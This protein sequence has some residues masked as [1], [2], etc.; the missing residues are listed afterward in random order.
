MRKE[1]TELA[2]ARSQPPSLV[3]DRRSE[4]GEALQAYLGIFC[5]L[6]P[7][8]HNKTSMTIKQVVIILLVGGSCLQYVK[9]TPVK[10]NIVKYHKMRYAGI[11]R[12]KK[13]A[14]SVFL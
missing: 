11:V 6:V 13:D 8:H 14:S 1:I 3:F 4:R 2:I 7:D 5:S 9:I 12:K 10:C